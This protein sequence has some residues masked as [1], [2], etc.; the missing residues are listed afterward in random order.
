MA[1][2]DLENE[3]LTVDEKVSLWNVEG[4]GN[5]DVPEERPED[6]AFFEGDEEEAYA[7]PQ[8]LKLVH[9]SSRAKHSNGSLE[10]YRRM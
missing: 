3:G 8:F 1:S 6:L 7:E 4:S 9:L 10:E 2:R 5:L